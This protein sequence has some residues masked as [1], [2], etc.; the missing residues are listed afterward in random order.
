MALQ[1]SPPHA[2]YWSANNTIITISY[3]LL[4]TVASLGDS[5]GALRAVSNDTFNT[6]VDD[7]EFPDNRTMYDNGD[8]ATLT[9]VVDLVDDSS[10][11]YSIP[12]VL[13]LKDGAPVISSTPNSPVVGSNGLLS[14]N[15]TFT[16]NE[17]DAGV[18]QCI[19]IGR[20][21]TEVLGAIPIRLD[22]GQC[23][24]ACTSPSS[25]AHLY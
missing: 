7:D 21:L 13:W 1:D 24:D 5:P 19:F 12:S 22:S 17:S 9:L 11:S 8:T 23:D 3:L 16:F 18:Y 4:L 6:E 2:W 20:N 15:L 10:S 14:T 25:Y